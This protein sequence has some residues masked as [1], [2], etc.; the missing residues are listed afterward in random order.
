MT[1]GDDLSGD[2]RTLRTYSDPVAVEMYAR[3]LAGQRD[4]LIT[5][6]ISYVCNG[7][8][9]AAAVL[10]VGA[11]TG[12]VV[13]RIREFGHKAIGVDYSAAMVQLA[14]HEYG[15]H[16]LVGDA[17]DLSQFPDGDFDAV[18]TI[19]CLHHLARSDRSR[20]I[21]ELIRVLRLGGQLL[22]VTKVG[23]G[24]VWDY[25]LGNAFPRLV[26]LVPDSWYDDHLR[27]GGVS[28]SNVSLIGRLDD[29][30]QMLVWR[31]YKR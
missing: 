12:E 24:E 2:V 13:S 1:R 11:G 25:R 30:Y 10:D 3:S 28:P 14:K 31:G 16:F 6:E 19:A 20:A 8:V 23:I 21:S 7:L 17:R 27:S 15:P 18:V 5:R 22:L 4:D 9:A 26:H 29:G